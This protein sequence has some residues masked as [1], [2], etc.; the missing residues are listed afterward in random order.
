ML[1]DIKIKDY[2]LQFINDAKVDIYKYNEKIKQLKELKESYI[3]DINDNID[4]IKKYIKIDLDN[5]TKE[6]IEKTYN[7]TESLYQYLIIYL[8]KHDGENEIKKYLI[9]LIKYCN[10]LRSIN[11]YN[12]YISF[13]N[14]RKSLP[15]KEYKSYV[16]KYYCKV[17]KCILEGNAYKFNNGIGTLIINY[18]KLKKPKPTIDYALT[19]KRKQEIINKGLRPY[20]ME[21]AKLYRAKGIP[22]DGIKY[23]VFRDATHYFDV[24]IFDSKICHHKAFKLQINASINHK[25]RALGDCGLAE[26]YKTI[27]EISNLQVDIKHKINILMNVDKTKYLNYVRTTECERGWR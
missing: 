5:Y 18:W 16:Y 27:E 10:V 17:H 13:A 19:Y 23:E 7:P 25:F 26:K 15:L 9:I 21:E 12:K 11:T 3:K 20:D 14:K 8:K 6:W 22:Y 1:P 2:Y 4:N 24:G